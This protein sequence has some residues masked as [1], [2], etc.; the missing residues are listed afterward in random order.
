MKTRLSGAL[1]AAKNVEGGVLGPYLTAVAVLTI[2]ELF[3]S[4][5]RHHQEDLVDELVCLLV[6]KEGAGPT[7]TVRTR[8]DHGETPTAF[9]SPEP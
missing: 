1:S 7:N 3:E 4:L 2:R 8:G 6:A 5:P 9:G